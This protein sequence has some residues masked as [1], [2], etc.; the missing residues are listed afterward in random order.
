MVRKAG[1]AY[2]TVL[3]DL[4][5]RRVVDM[6]PD[7]SAPILTDWLRRHRGIRTIAR[8]RSTEYAHGIGLG[9]PRAVQAADR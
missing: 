3:V 2:G 4:E 1:A 6:L 8:D 9:A 7:R 5:W